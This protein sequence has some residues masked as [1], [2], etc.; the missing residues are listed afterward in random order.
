MAE[1][2]EAAGSAGDCLDLL[3]AAGAPEEPPLVGEA[4]R[5]R[6]LLESLMFRRARPEHLV[7]A[8]LRT[9]RR[10]GG[11]SP[12]DSIVEDSA[13]E[14]SRML[15]LPPARFVSERLLDVFEGAMPGPAI[16]S[17]GFWKHEDFRLLAEPYRPGFALSDWIEAQP[18][19]RA[20]EVVG[21]LSAVDRAVT[22]LEEAGGGGRSL[23]ADDVLIEYP[24]AEERDLA[25]PIGGG[26][27]GGGAVPEIRIRT[28][29]TMHR[30][31]GTATETI[32]DGAE[33]LLADAEEG[34][35]IDAAQ[36]FAWYFNLRN[37]G[38][39][40][41]AGELVESLSEAVGFEEE[42]RGF[43]EVALL[44]GGGEGPAGDI[45]EQTAAYSPIA[46][47]LGLD[48][49]GTDPGGQDTAEGETDG[50]DDAATGAD[51]FTN[52]IARHVG[53]RDQ[54][55]IGGTPGR[56]AEV[57]RP[58]S[59]ELDPEVAGD[60]IS[61]FAGSDAGRQGKTEPRE[62]QDLEDLLGGPTGANP[63]SAGRGASILFL[64]LILML[65]VAIAAAIAHIS[66]RAFW[67]Q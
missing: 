45:E 12:Y 64:F 39:T 17:R 2:L 36:T 44:A 51:P 40:Y 59:D 46:A 6:L 41:Q 13:G 20:D 54:A 38:L 24:G 49:R 56:A 15:V 67:Q 65:S 57:E 23:R 47:A 7:P 16:A 66:G 50:I 28:H 25:L 63:E 42:Q 37:R 34:K 48:D 10:A 8:G 32:P 61:P 31:A 30:L 35:E 14:R 22:A 43:G 1:R 60:E 33:E 4:G 58:P 62:S 52:P 5:P 26:A 11:G 55:A 53:I 19:R 18:G 3:V 21:I 9:V 29:P 27:A